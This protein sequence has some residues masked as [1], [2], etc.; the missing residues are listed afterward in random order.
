MLYSLY[1]LLFIIPIIIRLSIV[2]A[3]L[4]K[5]NSYR[6]LYNEGCCN[7][8]D[9]HCNLGL[10]NYEDALREIGKLNINN[11]FAQT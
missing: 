3:T 6:E 10:R 4:C 11:K 2:I 5:K 7:E 9:C 8:N 1:L